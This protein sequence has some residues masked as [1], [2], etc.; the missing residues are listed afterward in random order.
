MLYS[1]VNTVT[2]YGLDN[3]G[4]F[5][6]RQRIFPIASGVRPAYEM[7]KQDL[8]SD[9]QRILPLASASRWALGPTQP[10]VQWV[11]GSFPGGKVWP[12]H[13]TDHSPPFSAEVR[14]E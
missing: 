5:P 7:D 12:R 3:Q 11:L 9:G 2:G 1:S 4:S 6:D 8:F 14:N 10:P 13:D